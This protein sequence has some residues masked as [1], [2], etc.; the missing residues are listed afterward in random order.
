MN[1]PVVGI[2]S[3]LAAVSL[4]ARAQDA[5]P[6]SSAPAAV[7][8]DAAPDP[9]PHVSVH[10][11]FVI[12]GSTGSPFADAFINLLSLGIF[13]TAANEH[14]EAH[15][16]MLDS[17][18]QPVE[19]DRSQGN[20]GGF[21]QRGYNPYSRPR[22]DAREGF[23]FSF[24]IGGGAVR[25]SDPQYLRGGALNFGLRLGYGF[26]DRFQLFG[27]FSA[28]EAFYPQSR[29]L[30]NWLVT[31]RGQTVLIGDTLGNGL[32]LNL[33]FGLG[34]VTIH[35]SNC[36]YVDYSTGA[37]PAIVGGLSYDARVS[38]HFALSPEWYVSWHPVPNGAG[39]EDDNFWSTGLRLNFLW[40][41][42]V[43]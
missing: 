27:D 40:Y 34:G 35:S 26:S 7:A 31:L 41:S 43:Y 24:G 2:F 22:H 20:S 33:G 28:D 4:A 3:A 13:A 37:A 11:G 19:P 38:R 6:A 15:Q 12:S 30:T 5:A 17:W 21:E 10:G 9:S 14:M 1:R 25:Y 36:C 18:R 23:L 29:Y 16:E 42:P 8:E 32:N 39:F